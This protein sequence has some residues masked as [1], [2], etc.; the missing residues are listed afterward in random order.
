MLRARW[1]EGEVGTR[2]KA[3]EKVRAREVGGSEEGLGRPNDDAEGDLRPLRRYRASV[4][5]DQPR[6]GEGGKVVGRKERGERAVGADLAHLRSLRPLSARAPKLAHDAACTF[7]SDTSLLWSRVSRRC[8]RPKRENRES[9]R[10]REEGPSTL[11]LSSCSPPQSCCSSLERTSSEPPAAILAAP[12]R[13]DEPCRTARPPPPG[14]GRL[15]TCSTRSEVTDASTDL[16][17]PATALVY[18]TGAPEARQ[19]RQSAA[20]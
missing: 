18:S 10:S 11:A 8:D 15:S 7:D 9:G 13:T 12:D 2:A 6:G 20:R 17:I 1:G 5:E 3:G 4:R 16:L 14:S 19:R